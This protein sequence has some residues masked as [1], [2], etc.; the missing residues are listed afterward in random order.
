MMLGSI[1]RI[2]SIKLTWKHP[3]HFIITTKTRDIDRGYK[4]AQKKEHAQLTEGHAGIKLAA[5]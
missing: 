1:F 2:Q 5:W 4:R 3:W